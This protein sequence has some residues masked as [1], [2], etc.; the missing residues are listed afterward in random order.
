MQVSQMSSNQI[1]DYLKGGSLAYTAPASLS[2][3]PTVE[4]HLTKE[5]RRQQRRRERIDAKLLA[6]YDSIKPYQIDRDA[7]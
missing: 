6:K 1:R 7:R 5:Q 3:L 4:T 2:A